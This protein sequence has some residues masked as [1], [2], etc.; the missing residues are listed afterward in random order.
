MSTTR[1]PGYPPGMG[2]MGSVLHR[3]EVTPG[4]TKA[5]L[6]LDLPDIKKLIQIQYKKK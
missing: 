1:A 5:V 4:L 6:P 3:V 2:E